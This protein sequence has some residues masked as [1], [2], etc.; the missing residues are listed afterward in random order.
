V[1]VVFLY[2]EDSWQETAL[3][4]VAAKLKAALLVDGNL[5]EGLAAMAWTTA[6]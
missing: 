5:A 3:Q 4:L 2:H 6:T 1:R